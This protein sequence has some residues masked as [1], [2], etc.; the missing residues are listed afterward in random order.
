MNRLPYLVGT[1]YR[2][3]ENKTTQEMLT[4]FIAN[5]SM[6][7]HTPTLLSTPWGKPW[8]TRNLLRVIR[9]RKRLLARCKKNIQH[10]KMLTWKLKLVGQSSLR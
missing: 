3:Y 2:L 4:D 8:V 6:A 1:F 9:L 10:L 7:D 5:I